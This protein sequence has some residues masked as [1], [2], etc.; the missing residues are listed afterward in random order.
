MTRSA[1]K[2]MIFAPWL[3]LL[4]QSRQCNVRHCIL[5]FEWFKSRIKLENSR[6]IYAEPWKELQKL[7]RNHSEDGDATGIC[8]EAWA[9][10]S[11]CH[12]VGIADHFSL[13]LHSIVLTH[14]VYWLPCSL[15]TL[16]QME[17]SH[18]TSECL[19]F[20]KIKKFEL[21]V[22]FLNLLF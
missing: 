11:H 4:W 1:Y 17:N 12:L 3:A 13:L 2:R 16:K 8:C 7:E 9:C 19:L 20:K 22:K 18:N 15:Y 21:I 6:R 10:P 14:S 5:A